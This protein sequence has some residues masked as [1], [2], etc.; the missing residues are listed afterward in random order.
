M[1]EKELLKALGINKEKLEQVL[2]ELR[3][4]QPIVWVVIRTMVPFEI[5]ARVN[6][7]FGIRRSI[8]AISERLKRFLSNPKNLASIKLE[9]QAK[10]ENFEAIARTFGLS[11]ADVRQINDAYGIRSIEESKEIA[12]GPLTQA[13]RKK[14][15]DHW[16]KLP[17]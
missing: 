7:F 8:P 1:E 11:A 6:K 13:R 2:I 5:V 16:R 3:K 15:F 9:L 14:A 17:K 4:K 10:Q 12:K